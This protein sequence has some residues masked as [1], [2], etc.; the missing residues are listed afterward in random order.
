MQYSLSYDLYITL[1]CIEQIKKMINTFLLLFIQFAVVVTV[2]GCK[3]PSRYPGDFRFKIDATTSIYDS[4]KQEFTR[5]YIK[6]DTTVRITLSD[7]ELQ[8]IYYLANEME[9]L[10]FPR[11]FEHAKYGEFIHPSF[12]TTIEIGYDGK[13]KKCSVDSGSPKIELERPSQFR[14]LADAI[15]KI[16]FAKDEVRNLNESDMVFL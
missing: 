6:G 5:R 10:K 1:F 12:I 13:N 2:L 7:A 3:K 14:E 15:M 4:E 16:L 9:F 11:E 8:S